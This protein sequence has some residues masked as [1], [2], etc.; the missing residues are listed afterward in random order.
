MA[1]PN[2][3]SRP[4]SE[5]NIWKPNQFPRPLISDNEALI[6]SLISHWFAKDVQD[7]SRQIGGNNNVIEFTCIPL[8]P[9]FNGRRIRCILRTAIENDISERSFE[10]PVNQEVKLLAVLTCVFGKSGVGLP[11]PDILAYDAGYNNV[12]EC[13]YLIQECLSGT[14]LAERLDEI[15][16]QLTISPERQN[17]N[18][19]LP[20][21][22][23]IAVHI[24]KFIAA[25]EKAQLSGYGELES[26]PALPRDDPNIPAE[27]S[28]VTVAP[29]RIERELIP[30]DL[31]F[32]DYI[33]HLVSARR[34]NPDI[35]DSDELEKVIKLLEMYSN[36]RKSGI[37]SEQPSVLW[38]ADFYPR[39]IMFQ[40]DETETE[41]TGVIDWDNAM[42]VS[43]H[44]L[45]YPTSISDEKKTN[46]HQLPRIMT[47]QPPTFLWDIEA[48]LKSES[49]E[50]KRVFDDTIEDLLPGYQKDAYS[51]DGVLVRGLG[52]YALF[53]FHYAYN[54]DL[55]WEELVLKYDERFAKQ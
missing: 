53:G 25:R 19:C 1:T 50:I 40:S 43:L 30:I 42:A 9:K 12:I 6:A 48:L 3:A 18:P 55:S 37:L 39:N 41:L 54:F 10:F 22:F 14:T 5:Q 46:S 49:D 21:R 34:S 45:V 33:G 4:P 27:S 24:A 36:M 11:I 13:P 16:L 47:R 2:K 38:H 32:A 31:N 29:V 35:S 7:C 28:Y 23:R 17:P 8:A 26:Q 20:E 51:T 52:W 15:D 44:P